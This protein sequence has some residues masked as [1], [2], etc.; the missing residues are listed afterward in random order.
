MKIAIG[1]QQ[2][3]ILNE[4]ADLQVIQSEFVGSKVQSSFASR[5]VH[6]ARRRLPTFRVVNFT[7]KP[8]SARWELQAQKAKC[9]RRGALT[10][11]ARS[12]QTTACSPSEIIGLLHNGASIAFVDPDLLIPQTG[13][14]WTIVLSA[15]TGALSV[16]VLSPWI[17]PS[18][19]RD[20]SPPHRSPIQQTRPPLDTW[21][22]PTGAS[23]L[24][25]NSTAEDG[26]FW[27]SDWI[28]NEGSDGAELATYDA[29]HLRANR[30]RRRR[31]SR[32][33]EEVVDAL[34]Q[35]ASAVVDVEGDVGDLEKEGAA[36]GA[37]Q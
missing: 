34:W 22:T 6:L 36:S 10:P 35:Q 14:L 3:R 11:T 23:T 33:Q 17:F 12:L 2:V 37:R 5:P 4:E 24:Q 15:C 28:A 20:S 19:P 7:T 29:R 31:A 25:S 32:S 30:R 13:P 9:R 1:V 18:N 16:I 27:P 21:Q 26:A 8:K